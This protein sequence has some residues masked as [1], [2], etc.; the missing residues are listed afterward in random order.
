MEGPLTPYSFLLRLISNMRFRYDVSS[1]T[2]QVSGEMAQGIIL[3][4]NYLLL[5]PLCCSLTFWG[6]EG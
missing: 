6:V 3:I 5:L 1:P 4:N 2:N